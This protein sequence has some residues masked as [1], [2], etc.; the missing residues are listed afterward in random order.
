MTIYFTSDTHFGHGNIIKY[1]NRPYKHVDEMNESLIEGWNSV[2]QKSDIVYHLGDFAFMHAGRV[3]NILN[4]LNGLKVLLYGNHDKVLRKEPGIVKRC[5]INA[6]EY[7]EIKIPD[8]SVKRGCQDIILSHYPMITWNKAHHGSFMLHGH[9]HGSLRYPFVGK[10][11]DVGVDVH[12]YKP[13]SY[14]Q[15]KKILT[16]R[17][18][19]ALD[20]HKAN[21]HEEGTPE[22]GSIK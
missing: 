2:V 9:C 13:I 8:L 16:P 3:E 7:L 22:D 6:C 18:I 15:V 17:K 14:E 4:R 21:M 10:I 5:F 11:L 19:T 1:T 20:H 12:S